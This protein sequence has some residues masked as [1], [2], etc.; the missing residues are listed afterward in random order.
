MDP[1]LLFSKIFVKI[2]QINKY[3]AIVVTGTE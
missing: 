2:K 3:K 1:V